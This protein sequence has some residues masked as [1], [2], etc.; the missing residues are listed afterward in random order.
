I[1]FPIIGIFSFRQFLWLIKGKQKLIVNGTDLILKKEGIYF[2]KPRH[3]NLMDIRNVR[4][5]EKLSPNTIHEK[6]IL[7]IDLAS[8]ILYTQ[9]LGEILFDYHGEKVKLFNNLELLEKEEIITELNKFVKP[10]H[11]SI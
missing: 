10:A 7:N 9:V 6:I 8:K 2:S 1:I 11:N 4:I 5:N 3:F